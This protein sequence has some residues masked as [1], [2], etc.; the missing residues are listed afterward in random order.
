AMPNFSR[1]SVAVI[2]AACTIRSVVSVAIACCRETWMVTGTT[3]SRSD[4]SI[5]TGMTLPQ[6]A[7]RYSVCPGWRKPAAYSAAL[8]IGL[9]T[10]AA[11]SPPRH[12]AVPVS[13]ARRT[14]GALAGSGCPGLGRVT[15]GTGR[16]GRA[17]PNTA[18]VSPGALI[19]SIRTDQPAVAARARSRSGSSSRKNGGSAALSRCSQASRAIS[20]PIP[21]GSPMVTASGRGGGASAELDGGIASQFADIALRQQFGAPHQEALADLVAV[22]A[23]AFLT[24]AEREETD[25]LRRLDRLRGLVHVQLRHRLPEGFG[26]IVKAQRSEAAGSGGLQLLDHGIHGFAA[27]DAGTRLLRPRDGRLDIRRIW[28]LAQREEDLLQGDSA[29]SRSRHR[30][31]AAVA[32][33]DDLVAADA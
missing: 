3:R 18:A 31:A 32:Q 6:S 29:V 21:A 8:W 33:R 23:A 1:R 14:A 13:M 10:R 15:S 17:V 11:A 7:A 22:E 5:I 24:G 2:R 9:V 19:V 25:T 28:R 16:T 26:K 12:S 4:A 30:N 20:P 27:V